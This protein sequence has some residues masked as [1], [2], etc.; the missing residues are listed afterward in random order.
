MGAG[1]YLC[2][3]IVDIVRAYII[4]VSGNTID[5][6]NICHSMGSDIDEKLPLRKLRIYNQDYAR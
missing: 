2:Y 1:S 3:Q 6:I 5:F 4:I